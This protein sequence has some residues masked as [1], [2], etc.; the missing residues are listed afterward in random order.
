MSYIAYLDLLGTRGFCEE[1]SVY[2]KNINNFSSTVETLAPILGKQGKIGMFSDCVYIECSKLEKI[3]QFLTE[4]RLMLIGDNLFFNAA[5]SAGELGVKS[6]GDNGADEVESQSLDSTQ[7]KTN[8]FGVR[9]TNKE[10]AAIYCKQTN[11]RGVGIW[12]DPSIISDIR[13]KV[14]NYHTISSLFYSKIE[15]NNNTQY[16]PVHYYDIPLFDCLN[17]DDVYAQQRKSDILSIILRVLYTSHCKSTKYSAYYISLLMNIIRCGD[18]S[19][20]TWNKQEKKFEGLSTELSI[21]YKFLLECDKNL[22]NLIGLDSLCLAFLD[23]LYNSETLTV[24]D[25]TSITEHFV[26]QFDC[27]KNKYKYSLD[28]VPREP[29]TRDNRKD[30]INFCNND[31]ANQFVQN[32]INTQI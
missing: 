11:F 26:N 30:F 7:K 27:L 20:F 2:Y 3:L 23:T 17:K 19:G 15:K 16:V 13:E 4:L 9:F 18:V 28:I 12:I 1:E 6:V 31:M 24:Y 10:I 21:M 32:V 5:L 29:F 22:N 8:I 25:K 14:P